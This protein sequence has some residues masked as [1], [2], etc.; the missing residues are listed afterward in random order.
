MCYNHRDRRRRP[1][2][3]ETEGLCLRRANSYLYL[4]SIVCRNGMTRVMPT[5]TT[6]QLRTGRSSLYTFAPACTTIYSYEKASVENGKKKNKTKKN[7]YRGSWVPQLVKCL[8]LA[9]VMILGLRD[10]APSQAPHAT[11]SMLVPLPP[12][13]SA[14]ALCLF[15][16]KQINL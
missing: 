15:P 9:Q 12:L 10:Q 16:N 14:H 11:G 2:T 4:N 13:L 5:S 8:P 6:W 3:K 7:S 1:L